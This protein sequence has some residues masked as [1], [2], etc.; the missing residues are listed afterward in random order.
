MSAVSYQGLR[1]K[2]KDLVDEFYREKRGDF[3]QRLVVSLFLISLL[4]VALQF[5]ETDK[6]RE[7]CS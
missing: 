2:Y 7:G 1:D 3:M 6:V 5:R 4:Q